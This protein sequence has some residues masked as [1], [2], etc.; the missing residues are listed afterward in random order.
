MFRN[1]PAAT[2][3]YLTDPLGYIE[4]LSLNAQA[5]LVLTDSG[6]LQEETTILGVPCVTIR[7]NTERPITV[8]E[9]TN[10]LAG[11]GRDASGRL[12]TTRAAVRAR[13]RNRS[14]RS[15]TARRRTGL[16]RSSP[17]ATR[18]RSG[19]GAYENLNAADR[20]TSAIEARTARSVFSV[21]QAMSVILAAA[22]SE[23]ASP[24]SRLLSM[25]QR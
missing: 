20:L 10:R 3:I 2:G 11:I 22:I 23:L 13:D 9:G 4:F 15:G 17:D 14:R 8:S 25:P 18:P 19:P 24:S 1:E 12:F 21:V 16:R 5:R 7:E 6:G